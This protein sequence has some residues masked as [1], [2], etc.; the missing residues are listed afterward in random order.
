MNVGT[1]MEFISGL[2]KTATESTGEGA[3]GGGMAGAAFD[4]IGFIKKPQVI[5]RIT[6]TV[7]ETIKYF[8]ELGI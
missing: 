8:F 3:Y 5:L 7:S 4:P 1:I 2:I 6:S